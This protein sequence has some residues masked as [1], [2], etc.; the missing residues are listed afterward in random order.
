MLGEMIG[1]WSTLAQLQQC[2]DLEK[3]IIMEHQVKEDI[4]MQS[5]VLGK[6]LVQFS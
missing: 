5:R 2:I 4:K 1:I 3:T 6:E